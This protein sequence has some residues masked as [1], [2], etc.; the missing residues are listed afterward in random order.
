MAN[1]KEEKTWEEG[2]YQLEVTDPVVGGIDGISNKQAKQLA[3]RTGYLREQIE[4]DKNSVDTALAK[5]RDVE[6][7]YSK[8]EVDKK[9]TSVG[10]TIAE[11]LDKTET[12]ADSTKLGGLAADKYALKSEASDGL[13]IGSYLLWSSDRTTPA[14]FLP[15]DGRRLQK[16][17]Y[18]ELFDVIGYTYGGSGE[19]FNL[20]KFNDGKFIRGTGGNAASLGIAQDDAIR[21]IQGWL[22]VM[23]ND[24]RRADGAFKMSEVMGSGYNDGTSD[25][26]YKVSFD[27]S[28]V[29]PVASENRPYNMSV[30]ILIKVKNVFEVTNV[31][32][33]PYATEIKAGIVKLKNSITGSLSDTA[34]SEKAVFDVFSTGFLSSKQQNGYAKLPSGIMLQ[35]GKLKDL[36]QDARKNL[37]FPISFPN[38]CLNASA[39]YIADPSWGQAGGVMYVANITKTGMTIEYQTVD[40]DASNFPKRDAF[41]FA[42]GY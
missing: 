29:V 10:T 36:E 8:T 32:K 3:N 33:S 20:P 37:T 24:I 28:N 34:V 19:H 9:F 22:A 40:S 31:D 14:G 23:S 21:N 15:A 2:I 16:S 12:A 11:K 6:D 39:T 42:I 30:I 25:P 1:I 18:I 38:A 27:A 41:W 13:K 7:S 4:N 17:E 5:K 35:W 26:V